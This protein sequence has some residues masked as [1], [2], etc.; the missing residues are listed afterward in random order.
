[1]S[2]GGCRGCSMGECP[3][4][5]GSGPDMYETGINSIAELEIHYRVKEGSGTSA[6]IFDKLY[7]ITNTHRKELWDIGLE[8]SRF[9]ELDSM[10]SEIIKKL[11]GAD[12]EFYDLLRNADI[13]YISADFENDNI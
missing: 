6:F 13:V 11:A 12:I 8:G 1:M 9:E 5:C 10:S 3:G 2:C 7:S 4:G